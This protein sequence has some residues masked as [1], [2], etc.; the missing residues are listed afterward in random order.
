MYNV[1]TPAFEKLFKVK[2]TG[3]KLCPMCR[4]PG[5]HSLDLKKTLY[6]FN[7][8]FLENTNIM[9]QKQLLPDSLT[10]DTSNLL[11]YL[12]GNTVNKNAAIK[13]LSTFF[14]CP[15]VRISGNETINTATALREYNM[16]SDKDYKM[17]AYKAELLRKSKKLRRIARNQ[18]EPRKDDTD[19]NNVKGLIPFIRLSYFNFNKHTNWCLFHSFMNV[20]KSLLATVVGT[21][22]SSDAV[23][24]YCQK[25]NIHPAMWR[26]ASYVPWVVAT[27]EQIDVW[28]NCLLVPRG[29]KNRLQVQ[30]IYHRKGLVRGTAVIAVIC[31]LFD[32]I[33]SINQS[34][35]PAYRLFF[36]LLSRGLCELWFSN[37]HKNDH[38]GLCLRITELISMHD[39]MIPPSESKFCFHQLMDTA[40]RIESFGPA[41]GTT[42]LANEQS[43]HTLKEFLTRGG[44]GMEFTMFERYINYEV[45]CTRKHYDFSLK[46]MYHNNTVGGNSGVLPLDNYVVVNAAPPT[47]TS[48]VNP[49]P[50][51]NLQLHYTSEPYRMYQPAKQ[52]APL[53]LC[54]CE[55]EELLNALS[56]DIY[57]RAGN[58]FKTALQKSILFR[59]LQCYRFRTV[60]DENTAAKETSKRTTKKL[61]FQDWLEDVIDQYN[62]DVGNLYFVNNGYSFDYHQ[63]PAADKDIVHKITVLAKI[64]INDIP[65]LKILMTGEGW[66]YTLYDKA[67]LFGCKFA[68]RG[69]AKREHLNHYR[70]AKYGSTTMVIN[71][72]KE[73]NNLTE[74]WHEECE[75]SSWCSFYCYNKR[76]FLSA[77]SDKDK[78]FSGED[79]MY[80]QINAFLQIHFPADSFVDGACIASVTSRAHVNQNPA[81]THNYVNYILAHNWDSLSSCLFIPTLQIIPTPILLAG[82]Y[83][84]IYKK[85]DPVTKTLTLTNINAMLTN[86][87]KKPKPIYV[88]N[89]LEEEAVPVISKQGVFVA[90]LDLDYKAEKS[91]VKGER[92]TLSYLVVIDMF[93]KCSDNFKFVKA[94]KQE[95]KYRVLYS[96]LT[97]KKPL[98][99]VDFETNN[100]Y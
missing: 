94:I 65:V 17:D 54:E 56:Q 72:Q 41:H 68:S 71:G 83:S 98:T 57:T 34:M 4:I 46:E 13:L 23:A 95:H 37:I 20:G 63:T 52:S 53:R 2:G 48:T 45:E 79:L 44:P 6:N 80:G 89:K 40:K 36:H 9:R 62:D 55:T 99:L 76:R 18:P 90:N 29:H 50:N 77:D 81:T 93:R 38:M 3:S 82:F 16:V 61:T 31:N 1:D 25:M 97:N 35:N 84:P 51:P 10:N 21:R 39:A 58:C 11:C 30:H 74:H 14:F 12:S 87:E 32:Y 64:Y 49:S 33:V 27:E 92:Q 24:A 96:S 42:T 26:G 67:D 19:V 7:R 43:L 85:I 91:K 70:P 66:S 78:Q 73:C 15:D 60:Y 69:F 86:N 8:D 88:G 100:K 22:A 75:Y 28:V 5:E 47:T 59:I